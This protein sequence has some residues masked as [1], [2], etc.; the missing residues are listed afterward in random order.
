MALVLRREDAV[1]L[2]VVRPLWCCCDVCCRPGF[3]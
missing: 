1:D 3:P 2:A